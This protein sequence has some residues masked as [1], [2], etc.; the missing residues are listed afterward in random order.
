[1]STSHP[2]QQLRSRRTEQ[3]LIEA[4]ICLL[5]EGGLAAC[6]VPA[7]AERAGVAVGSVYRRYA[8]KQAM[9]S[10]A[11]LALAAVPPEA[12]PQFVAI[13]DEASDLEDFFRRIALSTIATSRQNR[14]LILALR[15]FARTSTDELWLREYRRLRGTARALILNVATE[16]FGKEIPGGETALRLALSAIYGAVEVVYTEAAPGLYDE[17]PDADAFAAG[18][19]TMQVRGL[20]G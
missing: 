8:D 15:E 5:Q 19:A 1:M 6:T 18:L 17:T 2:P 11:I 10:A 14:A 16:R 3:R 12:A 20:M 13:V 4:T 9:V 7:V